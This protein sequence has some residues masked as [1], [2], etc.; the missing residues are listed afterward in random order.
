MVQPL[1]MVTVVQCTPIDEAHAL[2]VEELARAAGGEVAWV[3]EL[4]EAGIIAPAEP[5]QLQTQWR[6]HG[7]ALHCAVRVRRLQRDMEVGI[8]A[9]ALIVALQDEVRRLRRRLG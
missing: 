8:D 4:V 3:L 1:N 7:E 2:R 6:F 9:A 5:A